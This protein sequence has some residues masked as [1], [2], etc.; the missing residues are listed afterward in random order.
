MTDQLSPDSPIVPSHAT[1]ADPVPAAEASPSVG[2]KKGN[3]VRSAWIG[4]AG[5]VTAQ[6]IGAVATVGLGYAL[7]TK[8]AERTAAAVAQATPT[9]VS[10]PAAPAASTSVG[11][12]RTS[13]PALAVLPF[14]DFS[15]D[16]AGRGLADG[17][18]EAV[19]AA[20]ARDGRIHVTSRTSAMHVRQT[21]A[22]LRAIAAAL[23]VD[24][25]V[26]GSIV[27]QGRRARVTVQLID[28]ATDAHLWAQTYDRD[29]HDVLKF[30]AEIGGAIT[31]D[32]AS[33]LPRDLQSPSSGSSVTADPARLPHSAVRSAF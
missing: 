8:H 14:E 1:A 10:V 29:V 19:T 9:S 5:R 16:A 17:I 2:V 18:T 33:V 32:L 3:K 26:E 12:R 24:V 27:R 4:F 22:P 15:P 31:R 28:A 13:G 20:V 30:E 25:V 23:G 21:P 6:L 11:A 7:V